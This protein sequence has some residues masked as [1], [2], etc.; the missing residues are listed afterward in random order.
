VAATVST[1]VVSAVNALAPKRLTACVLDEMAAGAAVVNT[2]SI[3]G[4][5]ISR[6]PHE[7]QELLALKDFSPTMGQD[8]LAWMVTHSGHRR[9]TAREIAN[10]LAFLGSDAASYVSGSNVVLNHGFTG[11][12]LTKQLDFS[13]FPT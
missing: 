4:G 13:S 7:I 5:G 11:A 3:P 6:P 8:L 2:A 1:D 9:A 12:L 10:V